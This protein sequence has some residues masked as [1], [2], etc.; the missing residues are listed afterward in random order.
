MAFSSIVPPAPKRDTLQNACLFGTSVARHL[1]TPTRAPDPTAARVCFSIE[2]RKRPKAQ[3]LDALTVDGLARRLLSRADRR[4]TKARRPFLRKLHRLSTSSWSGSPP[5]CVRNR[6]TDKI[7]YWCRIWEPRSQVIPDLGL[8]LGMQIG[9]YVSV[10]GA[11]MGL[12]S[13]SYVSPWAD[14][15]QIWRRALFRQLLP[16]EKLQVDVLKAPACALQ[17]V[18]CS[19]THPCLKLVRTHNGSQLMGH[20][21]RKAG[22]CIGRRLTGIRCKL[23]TPRSKSLYFLVPSQAFGYVGGSCICPWFRK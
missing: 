19:G 17:D 2:G 9:L 20:D 22:S 18:W 3:G 8:L 5:Y 11:D 12:G 14:P 16:L 13:I 1:I 7:C 21:S 4:V 23:V 6:S 10:P 15:I